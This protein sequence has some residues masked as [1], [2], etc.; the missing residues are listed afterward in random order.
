MDCAIFSRYSGNPGNYEFD[1]GPGYPNRVVGY[2]CAPPGFL[3]PPQ[4]GDGFYGL[5]ETALGR[6]KLPPAD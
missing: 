4:R 1:A 3:T 6:L 5:V 2:Y